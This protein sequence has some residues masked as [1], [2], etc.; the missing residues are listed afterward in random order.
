MMTSLQEMMGRFKEWA[1]TLSENQQFQKFIGYIRDNAPTVVALIGN[2]AKMLV[3]FGI[4][5]APIGAKVLELVNGFVAWAGG[6]LK[7]HPWIGKIVAGLMIAVGVF[8]M[9]IPVILAVTTLFSGFGGAILRTIPKITKFGTTI[10]NSINKMIVRALPFITRI[11]TA[12]LRFAGGPI[13]IAIQAVIALGLIIYK[14]WDQ[15]KAWTIKA[16]SA[17]SQWVSDSWGK[18]VSW[19]KE[20]ASNIASTARDKFNQAKDAIQSAMTNAKNKVTTT[21]Q[22]IK[23]TFTSKMTNIV[24]TVKSKFSDMVNAVRGKMSDVKSK[25][26]DGINRV[27]SYLSGI[28]LFSMGADMIRGL[29]NGIGSMAGALVSKAKGVVGS[30]IQGAK[31]LLR[32]GSPSKVFHQFGQWT[33]EGFANGMDKMKKVVGRA[34]QGMA[35]AAYIEPQRMQMAFDSSISKSD[36]GR[37]KHE[38]GAEVSNFEVPDPVINVY[39]EWD[40]EKVVSYVERGNAKRTRLTDGFYGK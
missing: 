25:V 39:N 37:I 34:S 13:G 27:K 26:T 28:N 21:L 36:F 16:W 22:N 5:V 10:T 17:T 9:I 11:G 6:M 12:L 1:K 35:K 19:T 20:K 7:A 15:I 18:M 8:Q 2:L 40:G 33:G 23:S 31:N 3:N 24:S 29:I 30:A 32:I 14:N 38:F 4:A